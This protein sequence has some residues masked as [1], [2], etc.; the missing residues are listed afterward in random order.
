[1]SLALACLACAPRK[2]GS[3]AGRF[4]KAGRDSAKVWATFG[5]GETSF[6]RGSFSFWLVLKGT[7]CFWLDLKGTPEG[8]PRSFGG[9]RLYFETLFAG[10]WIT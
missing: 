10:E 5:G 7:L 4:E 9:F 2:P 6:F 8:I 3:T 1:M